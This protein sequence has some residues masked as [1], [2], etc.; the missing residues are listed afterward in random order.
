MKKYLFGIIPVIVISA[1]YFVRVPQNNNSELENQQKEEQVIT[2][3][4]SNKPFLAS[5]VL[6]TSGPLSSLGPLNMAGPVPYTG[7]IV[8]GNLPF[9]TIPTIVGNFDSVITN[10]NPVIEH[11]LEKTKDVPG[12]NLVTLPEYQTQENNPVTTAL[13][14]APRTSGPTTFPPTV[15][16]TPSVGNVSP[17]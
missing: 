5:E 11:L 16:G 7:P 15:Y 17:N 1:T 14:N 8:A 12:F 13:F 3:N 4:I 9:V 10:Y 2:T 6:N